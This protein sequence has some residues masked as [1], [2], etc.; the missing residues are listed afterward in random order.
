MSQTQEYWRYKRAFEHLLEVA[1]EER[2]AYLAELGKK[3]PELSNALASRLARLENTAEQP[4]EQ[5]SESDGATARPSIAGYILLA[6]AGSGGMG[7]VWLA[8]RQ[9]DPEQKLALK[10][11]HAEQPDAELLRRFAQERRALARLNHPHIASLVDAGL[12]DQGR[13]YL[14]TS[15]VDGERIDHWCQ[16]H[17]ASL[18]E[19][20][21]LVRDIAAA[22]SHAHSQMIVHRDLKPANVLVDRAGQVRVV[23][24]GIA[25]LM[26]LAEGEQV[27]TALPIMTLRYAAPE[28]V[29][30]TA[31]G[32]GCDLYALGVLLFELISGR[33]PYGDCSHPSALAHAIA[34][35]EP[36]ALEPSGALRG[37]HNQRDLNAIVLKL[38]RKRPQDRYGSAQELSLELDRWLLGAAV[39]ARSDERGYL[40]RRWMRRWRFALAAAALLPA[41]LG[42]HLWQL[43]QQLQQTALQ[44]DRARAVA[45]FFVQLF[46]Q[47]G[48]GEAREGQ[49]SAR[50]LLDRSVAQLSAPEAPFTA[51]TRSLLQWVS[52]RVYADLGM[53][54]EAEPLLAA[55][56]AQLRQQTPVPVDELVEAYR[57]HAGVLY[58]LDR[59]EDSLASSEAAV[60]L[61]EREQEID[62]ERY[63]G[64]LQNAGIAAASI[65]QNRAD[66]LF[67]RALAVLERNQA[68]M[69]RA[70]ILLLLNLGGD[71]SAQFHHLEASRYYDR[72]MRA[73]ESLQ[74]M[75]IDLQLSVQRAAF[76]TRLEL[77]PRAEQWPALQREL[78]TA[79]AQAFAHYGQT[80]LESAFWH[81]LLGMAAAQSTNLTLAQR[82]FAAA[83]A[84]GAQL[85]DDP[86]HDHRIRF[87]LN[88][89]LARAALT[90][91]PEKLAPQL[92]QLR[93]NAPA[94]YAEQIALL[95]GLLRCQKPA[96]PAA[97]TRLL[98]WQRELPPFR[99]CAL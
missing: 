45:D 22:L 51:A 93:A 95:A 13:P 52:A 78:D 94:D 30:G 31:I 24:F 80:H 5:T 79:S 28:Q 37:A 72:A 12:D 47:T 82:E 2:A 23:D 33:S 75:D 65:D 53:V 17:S 38:L 58:Q 18:R 96:D 66:V 46:R 64:M 40:L 27:S 42:W 62:S 48:P 35:G 50:T 16:E 83:E 91:E 11:L 77:G 1:P 63:A 88:V 14:V 41:L 74:P 6:Q 92:D 19:R 76:E 49:I 68:T 29:S 84:I 89:A 81:V 57:T 15:W 21:R 97:Q 55:A 56:I 3:E 61:L 98:R 86:E 43:D 99:R 59:V 44:R 32:P 20:V 85:F 39:H 7:K 69:R 73:L 25:K 87:A 71:Q 36:L 4:S 8:H 34:Q 26:D 70:Y 9:S 67:Q 60:E 54:R 10:Q 90:L